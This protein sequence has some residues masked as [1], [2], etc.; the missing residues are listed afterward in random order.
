M[1]LDNLKLKIV[2]K[3]DIQNK[4]LVGDTWSP[5][6]SM[7]NLKHSLVN[8]VKHKARLHKLDFIGAFL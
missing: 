3:G 7:M 2:V 5:T 6:S 4:E 8:K 1:C